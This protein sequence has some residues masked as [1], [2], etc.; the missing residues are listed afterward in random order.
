MEDTNSMEAAERGKNMLQYTQEFIG[1]GVAG[2]L[3]WVWFDLRKLPDLIAKWKESREDLKKEILAEIGTRI[4]D[5]DGY[6]LDE[7]TGKYYYTEKVTTPEQ[8]GNEADPNACS[9]G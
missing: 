6:T 1:I 4:D 3:S 7:D 8:A 9:C 2:M 5:K